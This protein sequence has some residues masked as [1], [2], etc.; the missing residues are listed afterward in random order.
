MGSHQ[1]VEEEVSRRP[2]LD[3]DADLDLDAVQTPALPVSP[4]LPTSLLS[5]QSSTSTTTPFDQ[6]PNHEQKRHLNPIDTQADEYLEKRAAAN[7]EETGFGK[8][9]D[10]HLRSAHHDS[11]SIKAKTEHPSTR[12]E[13][14]KGSDTKEPQGGNPPRQRTRQNAR[15]WYR[16]K[17]PHQRPA[18]KPKGLGA[19][20]APRAKED[21]KTASGVEQDSRIELKSSLEQRG[22]LHRLAMSKG[23]VSSYN[24]SNAIDKTVDGITCSTGEDVVMLLQ[25]LQSWIQQTTESELED[26]LLI[27]LNL[28]QLGNN[29]LGSRLPSGSPTPTPPINGTNT[30]IIPVSDED[31][32]KAL[33]SPNTNK[34]IKALLPNMISLRELFMDAFPSLIYSPA[35]L[36]TDRMDLRSTWWSDSRVGLDYYN[37]T[38]DPAT[39]KIQAPTGWPTSSYLTEVIKRRIVIGIGANNLQTNTSY[40]ITDDF[41]TLYEPGILGPSMTNS[42]LLRISSAFASDQCDYPVPGVMMTRTGSEENTTRITDG[43]NSSGPITMNVTWSFSSVSDGDLLPW[44]FTSGQLAVGVFVVLG[45]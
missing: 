19:I 6:K 14:N 37:T 28:N 34:T 33:V 23:L 31:F 32:F 5:T 9:R 27:V 4:A 43:R 39:G 22:R 21:N 35:Q 44:S 38:T 42:S 41:T 20:Q 11:Q 30:T 24:Q 2:L 25:A 13:K 40:N 17:K 45:I 7:T 18:I 36:Q 3:L 8:T 29:S 10:R 12:P 16:K 26:V 1:A 15:E